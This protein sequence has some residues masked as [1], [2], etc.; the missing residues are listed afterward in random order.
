[1]GVP[2]G[3]VKG[4][5]LGAGWEGIA[6]LLAGAGCSGR[7]VRVCPHAQLLRKARRTAHRRKLRISLSHQSVVRAG[8][9]NRFTQ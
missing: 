2:V 7:R 9:A 5:R 4:I 1:M 6:L 8:L 3:T